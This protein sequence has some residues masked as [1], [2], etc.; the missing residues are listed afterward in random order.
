[1]KKIYCLFIFIGIFVLP[2][3]TQINKFGVP[4]FRN[5]DSEVMNATDNNWAAVIDHRGVLYIG[6]ND[7][8]IVEYDGA[9]SRTIPLSNQSGVRSLICAE[10]GTVYVGGEGDFGYLAP[11]PTGFT[12]FVSFLPQLDSLG[13]LVETVYKILE[14][15]DDIYFCTQTTWY[16]YNVANDV[17]K[18]YRLRE[19]G[20]K[21][22]NRAFLVND[23]LYQGEYLAGLIEFSNGAFDVIKG[24]ET[25]SRKNI[26]SILPYSDSKMLIGTHASGV[27]LYDQKTGEIN[28]NI[29]SP[30][31]NDFLKTNGLYSSDLL[32]GKH[33]AFG[34]LRGGMSV[35]DSLGEAKE[36]FNLDMGLMDQ[37]ITSIYHNPNQI[38]SGQLWTVMYNGLARVE[39]FSPFRVIEEKPGIQGTI[40]DITYFNHTIY[41]ATSVG[42]FYQMMDV[43]GQAHFNKIQGIDFPVWSF[44]KLTPPDTNKEIFWAGTEGGVYEISGDNKVKSVENRIK[45][46]LPAGR[47]FDTYT[48]FVNPENPNRVF[49]GTSVSVFV[50]EYHRGEW[51]LIKDLTDVNDEVRS[52]SMDASGSLWAASNIRG[53]VR[54]D[55]HD[56]SRVKVKRFTTEEGLPS[57]NNNFVY[58]FGG[59]DR[60]STRLNSSH[61]DI[62]RMPSS[63]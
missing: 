28:K 36:I 21:N 42:V 34:T 25:F 50:I 29:L 54:F 46:L 41:V 1:M 62:S 6:N 31:V 8:G 7:V 38:E 4:F 56:T 49:I 30:G 19:N 44:L 27:Y 3:Q 18:T 48:L 24:G 22:G 35:L 11:D 20:F 55:L 57:L 33:F 37:Q 39:Y 5:F 59:Q 52:L 2:A 9:Q 60:K 51:Y 45:N 12:R 40:N 13:Q 10:D 15:E 17:L 32:P 16:A 43:S 58:F 26:L 63:A 61:T 14:F 47:K 53:I 23:H